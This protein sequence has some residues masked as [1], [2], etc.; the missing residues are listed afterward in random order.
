MADTAPRIV[1]TE[2][3]S[4]HLI[5]QKKSERRFR[6]PSWPPAWH[7]V[8]LAGITLISIFMDFFWL[9]INGYGSYYPPAIRSMMDSWHNF[10]FASYDPGGF[11][12]VDKPAPG[13][14]FQVL[15]AKI[16][17]FN[18]VSILLPQ[19]LAGVLSVLLLYYLVRRHFGVVAGLLAALALAVMPISVVTN[20]NI[21]MDSIL[22]L[23]LLIGAWAVMRAAETGKLRW[24]LL[25]AF[26]VGIGFNIKMMEAYLAVPAYAVLYLLTAPRSIWKRIGH[27][28][29]AGLVLLAVSFSWIAAVDLTPTS[30]RPYVDS[31]QDNSEL[32]LAL[33]YNGIDR[34]IGNIFGG[35]GGFRGA[36]RP[37]TSTN[38]TG[39][40]TSSTSSTSGNGGSTAG[41]PSNGGN[42][43][44]RTGIPSSTG[45][46]TSSTAGTPPTN[47]NG[48]STNP[49]NPGGRQVAPGGGG[50]GGGIFATGGASP[51]RL[52]QEDLGSQVSWLLPIALLGI[53][54]LA[55][56]PFRR[57]RDVSENKVIP[58]ENN[59]ILSD[60]EGSER[61]NEVVA[62]HNKWNRLS[63]F[64]ED[65][66]KK[67]LIFWGMWLLTMGIFFSVASFFH[68]YYMT[69]M[70]PAIAAL[71]GIGLVVMWKDFRAG[72]W[73]GWLLP[74]ALVA[75]VAEQIY[76]LHA[77]P[78]WSS[79]MVPIIVVL[80]IVA[81]VVLVGT[82][83]APRLRVRAPNSRFLLPALAAGVLAL[84]IA[85]TV[86]AITP[87]LLS[88]QADTL[89]AGPPQTGNFGGFGGGGGNN[90]ATNTN[91]K[92]I[93]FLE[94]NQGNTK[95]LVAVPSSQ[96]ITDQLIIET[97]KPVMSLGGF[98]G[99]D[100]ILTT[101]QL[102]TLVKNGTVRFFLLNSFGGGRRQLTPQMINQILSRLPAQVRSQVQQAL[103]NGAFAGPG[104]GFGGFGGG[105]QASITTWVT[106]NCKVVPTNLWQSSSTGS[107]TAGGGG[108]GFGGFGGS[109]QLYD[110]AAAQ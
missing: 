84:M 44:T 82:R 29:L 72:G 58:S 7:Q 52:F 32:T 93:S 75:T 40:S 100:P 51:L 68:Q 71:F 27:L 13:F 14:W 67:S 56:Q 31:T 10:F 62:E 19:A 103:K 48:G 61:N 92:L 78:T 76:L 9:G 107:G 26:I 60:S 35:R 95:F 15:S 28:A 57:R 2:P 98:S 55:W 25:S 105:Q 74:L 108:R 47:G 43:G 11:V 38:T 30:Q 96:G 81:L 77:Y 46:G 70:A 69:E 65:P 53:L 66:Q 18:P 6:L 21:T 8:A 39:R 36:F 16:F 88:K 1:Q 3:E 45:N 22:A 4:E 89:V 80:S 64:Q 34:L 37:N 49:G 97:N 33:G 41:T 54:A 85:P 94:A 42:G 99:S 104:G 109:S 101:S 90:A 106:Q 110:C 83:L 63:R 59:V 102:A 50:P 86:W 79:W 5:E 12:T 17:G 20:R 73:R 91:A 23:F 87:I 24:L